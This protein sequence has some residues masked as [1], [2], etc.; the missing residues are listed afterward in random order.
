VYEP[1]SWG[2]CRPGI[3]QSNFGGNC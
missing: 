1:G 3:G 2:S